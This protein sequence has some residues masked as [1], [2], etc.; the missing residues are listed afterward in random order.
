MLPN[1]NVNHY[2]YCYINNNKASN[3]PNNLYLNKKEKKQIIQLGII[4]GHM[5]S[6]PIGQFLLRRFLPISSPDT[7]IE[8][9]LILLPLLADRI[10]K[11]AQAEVKRIVYL[12]GKIIVVGIGNS[13]VV[14]V[15]VV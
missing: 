11:Q 5:N 15:V 2:Y 8:I 13:N 10:T 12:P 4:T 1:I 7:G 3:P 6:H 9:T 14:I